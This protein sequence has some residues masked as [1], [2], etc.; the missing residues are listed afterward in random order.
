[1]LIG[2]FNLHYPLW[3]R[4]LLPTQHTLA[5]NLIE[6]TAHGNI[7][8]ILPQGIVTWR[9]GNSMSTL[10]LAFATSG[11]AE[12]VLQRQPCEELDSDSDHI[13]IIT[14]IGISVPQ[15]AECPA[16]P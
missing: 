4:T 11:I 3:G 16:Q 2:D 14:S 1:M 13:P 15:Q 6:T 7:A 8:L 9:S 12:Q 10:D 5:D